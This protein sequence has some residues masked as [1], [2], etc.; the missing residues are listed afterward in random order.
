MNDILI[1]SR[2]TS[3]L[4]RALPAGLEHFQAS[5]Y[6]IVARRPQPAD[7]AEYGKDVRLDPCS[8]DSESRNITIRIPLDINPGITGP[9][10]LD[11][12]YFEAIQAAFLCLAHGCT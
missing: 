5:L 8:F 1:T 10:D 11:P 7:P 6:V 2:A 3:S 4:L 9:E 12:D